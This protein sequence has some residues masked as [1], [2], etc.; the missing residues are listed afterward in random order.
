MPFTEVFSLVFAAVHY[1]HVHMHL[2]CSH[3]PNFHCLWYKVVCG[4]SPV[5]T[6]DASYF[7]VMLSVVHT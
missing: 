6:D 4:L 7:A 3:C 5:I 2:G 1:G